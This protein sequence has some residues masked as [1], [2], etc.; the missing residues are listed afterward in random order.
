MWLCEISTFPELHTPSCL[1]CLSAGIYILLSLFTWPLLRLSARRRW[2][3]ARAHLHEGDVKG[4]V[5]P[6]WSCQSYV[7]EFKA[8]AALSFSL[9]NMKDNTESTYLKGVYPRNRV[10]S[11]VTR[12]DML[13]HIEGSQLRF[14]PLSGD[15]SKAGEAT[16]W[17]LDVPPEEPEEEG[18][19]GIF[20]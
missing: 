6:D 10:R 17:S 3:C 15:P 1:H 4:P 11:L 9:Q 16:S 2:G 18:C 19:L 12:R 8:V 5:A 13:L 14:V 7:T 20:A